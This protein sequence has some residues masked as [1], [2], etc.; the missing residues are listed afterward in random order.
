MRTAFINCFGL[1]PL[2]VS[3]ISP[4]AAFTGID[5][6]VSH[7]TIHGFVPVSSG[8]T[9]QDSYLYDVLKEG[10]IDIASGEKSSAVVTVSFEDLNLPTVYTDSDLGFPIYDPATKTWH[11]QEAGDAIMAQL[12]FD[13]H[14]VM[15]ALWAD[16]PF[17][18]FWNYAAGD[19]NNS[20][21]YPGIHYSFNGEYGSATVEGD[22]TFM[23]AVEEK[24]RS[25]INDIY[26]VNTDLMQ[27]I[28]NQTTT[29]ANSVVSDAAN[30]SDFDKLVYYKN[31]ICNAVEYDD[32]SAEQSSSMTDRGAWNLVNVF[33][34]NPDTNVVCEGY[35]EAFQYLC[36]LTH[37]SNSLIRGYCVSGVMTGATGAGN[38]KWNLVSMP[39]GKNYVADITVTDSFGNEKVF[40]AGASGDSSSYTVSWSE[41]RIEDGNQIIIHHEGSVSY[42][43]DEETIE[44]RDESERLVSSDDYDRSIILP[45]TIT[46]NKTDLTLSVNSSETL[47]A[48]VLPADAAD[49]TISWSSTDETVATVDDEGMVT[50][51]GAGTATIVAAANADPAVTASCT[52]TV[53]NSVIPA[54]AVRGISARLVLQGSILVQFKMVVPDPEHTDVVIN[55]KGEDIRFPAT[56]GEVETLKDGTVVHIYNVPVAAKE[57][58][59]PIVIN[60]EDEEG[61]RLEL[62]KGSTLEPEGIKYSVEEYVKSQ[63]DDATQELEDLLYAMMQYGEWAQKQFGHNA[64][65][66]S[67]KPVE[68]VEASDLEAYQLWR[69]GTYPAGIEVSSST[70]ILKSETTVV[71]KLK[72]TEGEI[73]NYTVKIDGKKVTLTEENG[74]WLA[75]KENI[76]A[77]GLDDMVEI[78]ISK[79]GDS[80]VFKAR[81]GPLTYVYNQLNKSDDDTL[82]NLCKALYNYNDKANKY[83]ES[84]A[85]Q[86]N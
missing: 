41:E 44:L 26:S 85:G 11:D 75:K 71:F 79:E 77:K 46:L 34:D 3:L 50:A 84:V 69:E 60:F 38:H 78:E 63:Q 39:D 53:T 35:A 49:K 6:Y 16:L 56:D 33:D 76:V 17:E 59:E 24:Y 25:D 12:S 36:D 74:M 80:N 82:K 68:G 28:Y 61:K 18:M 66:V 43:Y 70:L 48:E 52:V 9:G 2:I 31:W 57:M 37:F 7:D 15:K 65:A 45:E 51:V 64:D 29:M 86:N 20:M 5:A 81:Y 47:T 21:S 8:L 27:S 10:I 58:H 67:P 22:L 32:E 30:L 72:V 14:F 40:F 62:Y 73:G 55:Y 19:Y 1:L 4:N 13:Y 83:F 54:E 42:V 23:F